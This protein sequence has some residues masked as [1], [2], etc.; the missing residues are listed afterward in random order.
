ML[1]VG[2]ADFQL[3][4]PTARSKEHSSPKLDPQTPVHK[5]QF[6]PKESISP[7]THF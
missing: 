7:S 2:A 4:C 6:L 1:E 5:K 3:R